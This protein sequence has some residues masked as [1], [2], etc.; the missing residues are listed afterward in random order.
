MNITCKHCNQKIDADSSYS[1]QTVNCPSC[2]EPISIPNLNTTPEKTQ[3]KKINQYLPW[4]SLSLAVIALFLHFNPFTGISMK[5]DTPEDAIK[6]TAKLEQGGSLKE[7]RK[8]E[9]L[10]SNKTNWKSINPSD[11]E[12]EKTLEVKN[13][14]DKDYDGGVL[15]FLKFE[16]EDGVES[17]QVV[18]L[19]KSSKGLF[20]PSYIASEIKKEYGSIIDAWEKNGTLK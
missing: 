4:I 16:K 10:F 15:C 1:G 17:H 9:K 8:A 13:T 5:F 6:T 20:K 3:M 18:F 12:I 2:D 19:R 7:L 14:G 11:L